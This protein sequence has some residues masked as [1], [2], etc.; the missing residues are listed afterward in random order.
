M[1]INVGVLVEYTTGFV[2]IRHV[3]YVF[4][5]HIRISCTQQSLPWQSFAVSA[6]RYTGTVNFKSLHQLL[7]YQ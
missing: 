5:Q 1:L 7:V 6:D 2:I 3:H 4:L